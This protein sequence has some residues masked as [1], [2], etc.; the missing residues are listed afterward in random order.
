M[1]NIIFCLKIVTFIS[2]NSCSLLKDRDKSLKEHIEHPISMISYSL[3]WDNR[4]LISVN[5][6][7][8]ENRKNVNVIRDYNN[9]D[10]VELYNKL[11]DS[12]LVLFNTNSIDTRVK[13][14]FHFKNKKEKTVCISQNYIYRD[15]KVFSLDRT[16]LK[17]LMDKNIIKTVIL[18]M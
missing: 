12:T 11:F 4:Y 16:I 10:I 6:D 14:I 18:D 15:D 13:I 9:E 2:I 7:E 1:K 3:P 8:I 5:C 17:T